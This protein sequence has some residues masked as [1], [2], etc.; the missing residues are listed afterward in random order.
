[1]PRSRLSL[2]QCGNARCCQGGIYCARLH[3]ITSNGE[4]YI[5]MYRLERG[6]R[7]EINTCQNCKDW[8]Y[9]DEYRKPVMAEDRGWLNKE[10]I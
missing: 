1:M 10:A 8:D 6:D 2:Y 5:S 9:D 7:L 4:G 3:S